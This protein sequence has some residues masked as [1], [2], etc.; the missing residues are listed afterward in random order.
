MQSFNYVF[1]FFIFLFCIIKTSFQSSYLVLPFKSSTKEP[2][3]YPENLLQN[4]L[5][6]TINIGTPPQSIGLNLRSKAYTFFVT[7]VEANLPYP[8]FNND[9]SESLIKVTEK[10]DT[11]LNQ[12]YAKGFMIYESIYINGKE[13][14]SISL[15]LATELNYR[16]SGALGL[17]LVEEHES[18]DDL[19]FI[20]QMKKALNLDSYSYMINYK[21]NNEGE[22]IIGAYPHMYD[23][24]YKE[25]DFYY[26]KAG[27]IK[28]NV[29]WILEL[30]LIKYDNK[31]IT[32]INKQ[33][34]TQVEFGLIQAPFRLK[35]YL[36]DNFFN[37]QCTEKFNEK[38][39]ITILHCPKNI[40]IKSFKN[41]TFILKDISFEFTLT[42]EDLFIKD[43][44]EYIF[45]I[46]FDE[47][48]D[49]KDATWILGK[50]FMKKY[51]LIYDLDRKIIGAYKKSEDNE[52]KNHVNLAL[53]I[54][55]IIL[56]IIVV[57]LVIFIIYFI[58]KPRKSKAMELNDDNYDYFPT[59]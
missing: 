49:N 15:F 23:D 11:F 58:K 1:L 53:L 50:P 5:E 48:V 57:G 55:L 14:K 33:G 39:N 2:K 13:I 22:L 51:S 27:T 24:N 28:N 30:D 3:S 40:N 9:N 25:K 19:S 8:T 38:R 41:L 54:L 20:L 31:T 12:E 35:K 37:N 26:T 29:D 6:V 56:G 52:G 7:S 43:N 21:S 42:Y 34:F 36:N 45:G 44:D 17:R 10:P 32:L 4:D 18:G 47:N 16:E 59:E 46:V